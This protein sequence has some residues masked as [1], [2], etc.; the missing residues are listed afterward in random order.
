MT[1]HL[2]PQLIKEFP[3]STVLIHDGCEFRTSD[4]LKSMGMACCSQC[5]SI[6]STF[7]VANWCNNCNEHVLVLSE[8]APPKPVIVKVMAE[9]DRV[10]VEHGK[11]CPQCGQPLADIPTNR[12]RHKTRHYGFRHKHSITRSYNRT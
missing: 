9:A 7:P 4:K 6:F 8:G 5:G 3:N 1:S 10:V 2:L 12:C 11:R